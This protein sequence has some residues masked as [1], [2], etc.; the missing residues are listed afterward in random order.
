VRDE[1]FIPKYKTNILPLRWLADYVF[2]PISM[3][4]FHMGLNANDKLEYDYANCT[5]LDEVKEKVGFHIYHYLN[6][7]YDWWGTTYEFK[8]P[9]DFKL[10]D[11]L[12]WDDYDDRGIPYWDYWWHEDPVTGDAWRIVQK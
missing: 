3:K 9:A 4:F 7:P 10:D 12:G 2:H 5:L 8:L 11:G 1:I 6:H